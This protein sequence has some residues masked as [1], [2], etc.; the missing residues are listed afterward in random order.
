MGIH[1]TVPYVLRLTFYLSRR[2][3]V[4]VEGVCYYLAGLPP[5]E[6]RAGSEVGAVLVVAW[7]A[8]AAAWIA[9]HYA[10]AIQQ[11]PLYIDVKGR[12]HRHVGEGEGGGGWV[13]E[14]GRIADDL[15]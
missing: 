11:E 15:G 5:C 3:A 9:V 6:G 1:P 4:G 12:S 8:R 14:A 10:G 2:L 7:L 13:V